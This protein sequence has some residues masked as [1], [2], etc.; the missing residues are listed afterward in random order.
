MLV[1]KLITSML[2]LAP[3][4]QA[5][6][7]GIATPST[8]ANGSSFTVIVTTANFIQSVQDVAMSFGIAPS[9]GFPD[10]LGSD[11]LGTK[12]LGR[13]KLQG[14]KQSCLGGESSFE[15]DFSNVVTNITHIVEV[16][17]F[18]SQGPAVFTG[19]LFSLLGAAYS[20]TTHDFS[21]NV[22]VGDTT[23]ADYVHSS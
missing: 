14:P 11:F 3:L 10:S 5:I 8:V 20:P 12:V 22:T 21:V 4:S 9:P 6:I 23:S 19:A 17:G 13:G 7:T 15:T 18:I 16:P 2:P 1:A